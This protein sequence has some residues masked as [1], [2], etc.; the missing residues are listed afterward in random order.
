MNQLLFEGR[1]LVN[2]VSSIVRGES[3]HIVHSR[4]DW[5]R[6]FHL[7]EYHGVSSII[8]LG[9]LGNGESMP[10][11][12]CD[13][14]FERYQENLRFNGVCDE[15][16]NEVLMLFDMAEIPCFLLSSSQDRGMYKIEET[17]GVNPIRILMSGES[18]T[19]AKGYL[20]NLGYETVSEIPGA[21]ERMVRS[22]VT[23]E[24]YRQLPF[25]TGHY[26]KNMARLLD[27]SLVLDPYMYVRVMTPGQSYIFRMAQAA[28]KYVT[29]E[30]TVREVLD[31]M[32]FDRVHYEMLNEA[33]IISR[34][35]YFGVDELSEKILRLSYMWFG[36]KTEQRFQHKPSD[37]SVYDV[38]EER[39]LSRGVLN[40]EV[41][42]QA[43]RLKKSIQWEIDKEKRKSRR[44]RFLMK[45]KEK[46]EAVKKNLRWMF[47][48]SSYMSSIYPLLERF[49][50]LLPVFWIVRG[51]RLT[52]WHLLKKS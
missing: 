52:V 4:V 25:L 22:G 51:I 44:E 19:L 6:M 40:K 32:L 2:I 28:Y 43:I 45:V 1:F 8:Y 10:E 17:A 14:F 35:K 13:R 33:A 20:I 11:R 47:P 26:R 50:F 24:L 5:E 15:A 23:V 46:K 34:L 38:L 36:D 49:S 30:L 31:L 3:I 18:Y 29:D 9:I 48:N 12:W 16:E 39:L 7:A 42:D 41:N 37:M 21:G 27:E